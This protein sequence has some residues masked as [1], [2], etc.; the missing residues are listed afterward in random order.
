MINLPEYNQTNVQIIL[1]FTNTFMKMDWNLSDEVFI[2]WEMSGW[3]NCM[4]FIRDARML[5]SHMM[6]LFTVMD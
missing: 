1:N 5:F 3:M 4:S 2:L 6:K